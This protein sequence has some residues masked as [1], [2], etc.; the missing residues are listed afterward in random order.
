MT[1]VETA[2]GP[3]DVARLGTTFMHEHV[4]I[5]NEEIR[6]NYPRP[7]GTRRSGSPTRPRS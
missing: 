2:R 4:F 3:V 1:Q 7:T 5:L 6:Q